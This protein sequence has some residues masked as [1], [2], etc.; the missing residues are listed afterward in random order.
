MGKRNCCDKN[1]KMRIKVIHKKNGGLSDARNKGIIQAE[2]EYITFID[3]D[4][5]VSSD[6][7]EYL[8]NILEENDGDIAICNRM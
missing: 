7:V 8:Y 5:V 1:K 2:G 3:S 6:Y 4:D